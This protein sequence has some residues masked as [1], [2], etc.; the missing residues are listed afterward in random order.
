MDKLCIN[1]V[2]LKRDLR[3]S[4]HQPLQ[5]AI[6]ANLPIILLYIFEPLQVS[7]PHYD[8]RH[9]RFVWQSLADL[10]NQLGQTNSL[11]LVYQHAEQVFNDL[12]EQYQIKTLYSHQEV[13]LWQTF[14][15]DKAIQAW[16]KQQHIAWQQSPC[17]GVIRA[18]RNRVDWD[19]HWQKVMRAP[20]DT[21]NLSAL[22][23]VN[24]ETSSLPI[25]AEWQQINPH[26]Q[27]GGEAWAMKTMASFYAERGRTYH[28][29]ISKPLSSRKSCSRLSPYLAWGNISLKQCYQYLLGRWKTPGWQRAL[30]AFSSRLHWHC[31]FIQKFESESAMEF[32]PINRGYQDFEYRQDKQVHAH[33]IAW[34][35]GQT[36][37]PLVD[38]CMRCL[39]HTGY[40][41]FRMRAMLVSFLCHHLMIDWRLGVAYLAHLFLDFEPGI[42]YPQ[43]QMQAGVTGTNTIRIYN[44]VK[45]SQEHDPD[46]L[47]IKKWLPE[48]DQVPAGLCHQPWQLT[49]MEQM[50]YQT[51]IPQDYPAPIINIEQTGQHAREMLWAF[52]KRPQVKQEKRRILSKHVRPGASKNRSV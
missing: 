18:A 17:G 49:A 29:F 11:T 4:D 25:P 26:M 30:V 44:P 31:H 13:G 47:F 14:E 6:E 24:A 32:E 39:K 9:W 23:T 45:Q 50:M 7:D 41:N 46:A 35:Q 21:P 51:Y 27:Q 52:K 38:A 33:L 42:H 20:L 43:F 19:K 2:W 3:L 48:L 1:I 36:G 10:Q 8:V 34:Q 12:S 15:R 37:Y 16:C 28:I 22:S 5:R 40:I